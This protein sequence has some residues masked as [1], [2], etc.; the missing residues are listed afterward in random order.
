MRHPL[1]LSFAWEYVVLN[2][3]GN[4]EA[5]K[6]IELYQLL[7]HADDGHLLGGNIR[8]VG[9]SKT[10]DIYNS[11][12]REVGRSKERSAMSFKE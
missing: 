9:K 11:S 5:L 10:T 4:E 2:G 12:L 8:D 3:Q 7:F 1:L 6:M